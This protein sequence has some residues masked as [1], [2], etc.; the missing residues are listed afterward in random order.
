MNVYFAETLS[1]DVDGAAHVP[2]G[3]CGLRVSL[4]K[5][6]ALGG[7]G[8]ILNAG[9]QIFSPTSIHAA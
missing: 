8:V 9:V 4:L 3:T 2:K 6:T 7:L 5:K 1:L